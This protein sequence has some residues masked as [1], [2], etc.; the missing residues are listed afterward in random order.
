ME[1]FLAGQW[2]LV[3]PQ[4]AGWTEITKNQKTKNE[5]HN[6]AKAAAA[7]ASDQTAMSSMY[8][9]NNNNNNSNNK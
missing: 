2:S 1:A 4:V 7:S 9:N 5:A 3:A 8:N 6:L